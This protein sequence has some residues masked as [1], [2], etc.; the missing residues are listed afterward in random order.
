MTPYVV[1]PKHETVPMALVNREPNGCKYFSP[2]DAEFE[3]ILILMIRLSSRQLQLSSS[4]E[5]RLAY[6]H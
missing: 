5:R 6:C 3:V 4:T 1:L 2:E